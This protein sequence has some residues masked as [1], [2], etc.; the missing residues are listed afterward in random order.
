MR[1]LLGLGLIMLGFVLAFA[2]GFLF[3]TFEPVIKLQE[4]LICK[5][6]ESLVPTYRQTYNSRST[7]TSFTYDYF[8]VGDGSRDVSPQVY[9]SEFGIIG[10]MIILGIALLLSGVRR[11][12]IIPTSPYTAS[13]VNIY[14]M[15]DSSF[16][17]STTGV[18]QDGTQISVYTSDSAQS[19]PMIA[20]MLAGLEQGVINVP[21]MQIRLDQMAG[22]PMSP[23]D[24]KAAL[25]GALQQLTEARR[26]GWITYEDYARAYEQITAQLGGQ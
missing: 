21:G 3:P 25:E 19:N 24:R 12:T 7:G 20:Q 4:Q 16:G 17:Q 13:Q 1:G 18:T 22:S 15:S 2:T 23:A 8:C 10:P 26:Q 6:G 14:T 9:L 11:K 5:S